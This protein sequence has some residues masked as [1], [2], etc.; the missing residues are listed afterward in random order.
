MGIQ[1]RDYYRDE[2]GGFFGAWGRQGITVWLIAITCVLFFGQV[3]T[4]NPLRNPLV[5]FGVYQPQLIL[6]GQVWRLLT[7][8]FLHADLVHLICNMI[9]LYWAGSR[10]EEVYGGWE[11]LAFYLVSG[12][13]ASGVYLAAYVAGFVA[14]APALGASG[15][16]TAVLVLCAFNFPRLQVL[17]FFVIPMPVWALAVLYVVVDTLGA[18]GALNAPVGYLVHLAGAL[19]ASVYYQ[20]GFRFRRVLTRPRRPVTQVRPRLRVLPVEPEEDTPTPVGAAVESQPRPKEAVETTDAQLEARVD[21]VLAKVSKYGQES[22][23][24]EEREILAK[25]SELHKKRRK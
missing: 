23:T 8:V 5:Q 9:I 4:G 16:V 6:E 2:S 19:F 18:L 25:A 20:T 11:V 14:P 3:I 7:P 21:Q 12:V 22:L 1:D 10:V 13:F 17:L 15:A 24:P